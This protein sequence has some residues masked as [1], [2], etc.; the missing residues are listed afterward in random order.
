MTFKNV[1]T[2]SRNKK[3]FVLI[4]E[5]EG[6]KR[7]SDSSA[8]GMPSSAGLVTTRTRSLG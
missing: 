1:E 2:L 4:V 3:G 7:R 6:V 5:E 8:N